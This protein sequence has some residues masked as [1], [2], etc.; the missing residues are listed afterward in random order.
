MII[1]LLGT[2]QQG[3]PKGIV[4]KSSFLVFY[5]LFMKSI[6]AETDIDTSTRKHVKTNKKLVFCSYFGNI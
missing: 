5:A 4:Y 1:N 6:I 2:I 3:P